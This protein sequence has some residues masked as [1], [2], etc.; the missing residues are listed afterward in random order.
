LWHFWAASV[1][2]C[3]WYAGAPVAS[4]LVTDL[5]P[6]ESLSRGLA[7]YNATT[8]LGGIAG[9]VLTGYAVQS[10]GM[11]PT[12]IAGACL[13]LIAVSL[14]AASGLCRRPATAPSATDKSSPV[15]LQPAAA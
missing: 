4:A 8:W 6:R 3:L 5:V 7:L 10:V 13:P 9:C 11:T 15:E 12:L 2:N 1:L 14:L